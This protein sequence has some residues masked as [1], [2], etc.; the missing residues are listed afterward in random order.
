MT[1]PKRAHISNFYLN[2]R[3]VRYYK[4]DNINTDILSMRSNSGTHYIEMLCSVAST[5]TV[6]D[7]VP[8]TT[9][10]VKSHK[11]CSRGSSPDIL[12]VTLMAIYT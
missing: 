10:A 11:H 8:D 3:I 9:N 12:Y 2:V 1:L 5:N 7:K 4:S 6:F